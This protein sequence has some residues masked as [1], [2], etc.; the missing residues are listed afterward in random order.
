MNNQFG[1][2][3][4]G[5]TQVDSPNFPKKRTGTYLIPLENL[6]DVKIEIE[7]SGKFGEIGEGY[8]GQHEIGLNDLDYGSAIKIPFVT[9]YRTAVDGR[10]ESLST[11]YFFHKESVPLNIFLL[12]RNP[13]AFW[14]RNDFHSVVA[15]SR[16]PDKRVL[17]A[18]VR[19][20]DEILQ[21]R[22][23]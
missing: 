7:A 15:Y 23:A 6:A 14:K 10:G 21:S 18:S 17:P 5:L 13:W 1:E 20:L 9:D 11:G 16:S 19:D 22:S 2:A 8:I 4:T 12:V 3:R